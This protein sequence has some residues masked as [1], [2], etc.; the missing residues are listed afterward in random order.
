M[1]KC[2]REAWSDD[3]IE[4]LRGMF[5]RGATNADIAIALQ[6]SESAVAVRVSRLRRTRML[7]P[8]LSEKVR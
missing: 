7:Q 6:R 4:M 5:E 3:D 8:A 1:A 2:Q